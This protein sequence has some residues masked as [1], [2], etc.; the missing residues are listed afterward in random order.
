MEGVYIRGSGGLCFY[1]DVEL[2]RLPAP[3]LLAK[4]ISDVLGNDLKKCQ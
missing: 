4:D 2:L 1:V 3:D